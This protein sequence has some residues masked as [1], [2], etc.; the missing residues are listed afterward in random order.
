MATVDRLEPASYTPWSPA[1]SGFTT[2]ADPAEVAGAGEYV[3][4]HR[5][6]GLRG[7]GVLRL[8]YAGKHRYPA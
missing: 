5:R 8:L 7:L 6:G 1:A 2:A 3:G 4:K